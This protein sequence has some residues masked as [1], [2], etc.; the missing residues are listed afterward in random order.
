MKNKILTTI[1]FMSALAL[2]VYY[3][4]AQTGHDD[5]SDC[6][7]Q[8]IE[9]SHAADS[10]EHAEDEHEDHAHGGEC[11]SQ[12]HQH[13]EHEGEDSDAHQHSEHEGEDS[14][15]HQHDEDE[16]LVTLSPEAAANAGI[17]TAIAAGGEIGIQVSLP[18][19]I[20][21]N[22]DR[23]VHIVPRVEGVVSKVMKNLGDKVEAGEIIAVIESRELADIKAA[24]LADIERLEMAQIAF[25]R[26]ERLWKQK[27]S[28]E[29]EYLESRQRLSEAK[30][31]F[32]TS[33]QK[34]IAAGL[35]DTYLK[36]LETEPQQ[37]LTS[38]EIRAP[39]AGTVIEKH[40]VLGELVKT[41]ETVYII[42]DL[43][44]VWA[45]IDVYPVYLARI[46]P[47]Q[48]VTVKAG[49]H[50]PPVK[51]RIDYLGGLVSRQSRTALARVV[52]DNEAG[53]L[54]PGL[55][56]NA[57]VDVSYKN[58]EVVVPAGAVQR[59]ENKKCVFVKT[60]A[61]FEPVFI[62]TGMENA[63]KLEVIAGLEPGMEYVVKGGFSLKAKI[64]TS[65]LDSH[66]GHGH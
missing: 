43:S 37:S 25:D 56:I 20:N 42:A 63:E 30:I 19:E 55:Y 12:A 62:E 10:G 50:L 57:L 23:M 11:E 47:G 49:E 58:C 1:V 34:L 5:H 6:E 17:E 54:R 33:K 29:Q 15:A 28:A 2:P 26:E 61:G 39:F 22:Q 31:N 8:H 16:G 13:S 64:V 40:I 52:L 59:L 27:I 65:T 48:A 24:Y 36:R 21:V 7:H 45:D 32:R 66:A 46:K 51:G 60:D 41:D 38:F 14:D 53:T 35:D 18:G 4:L 3:T 9:D 44:N